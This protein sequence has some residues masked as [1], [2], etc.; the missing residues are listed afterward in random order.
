M[1]KFSI[2]NIIN[3]IIKNI[4]IIF[5]ISIIIFALPSIFYIL[6]NKTLLNF[7]G[8]LEFCFLL[9]N[10]INRLYQALVYTLI[11]SII[12]LCYFIIIKY[13]NQIFKNNKQIFTLI[14]IVSAIFI[15]V[16]PFWCSDLFYYLGIGRITS[17]YNQNP[18]Y[19]DIKSYVDNNNINIEKDTV[20]QKGYTNYWSNT[21]VVY[22]AVWTLICSIVSMLS[23]GNL[24][25]GVLI[26]KILNLCIHL[27]NCYL[28]YKISNKKIFTIIYGFNPFILI[29]GLAN[30]HNDMFVIFFIL[31]ALYVLLKKRRIVPSIFF[32][33]MSADIKYFAIL[34]LPF[35][36]IS[37]FKDKDTKTRIIKCIEY[38]ILFGIF[39]MIPYLLYYRDLNV[40][41]GII[42]QNNKTAKGIY[43]VLNIYFNNIQNLVN[44]VLLSLFAIGYIMICI[45]YL[46]CRD[47]KFTKLMR[48]MYL[49]LLYFIF[50]LITNFQPWYL[51]WLTPLIIWQ[52]HQNI[53]LI[54]QM[55]LLTLYSN[56]VFLMYS[57][58]YIYGVPFFMI[59][60]VGILLCII[61]NK[62][63]ELH[64]KSFQERKL[65]NE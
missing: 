8:N 14:C 26:F 7:N 11:I 15:F 20:M 25:I 37:Y 29:E 50:L 32:L 28:I 46:F 41:M 35:I 34:F 45:K 42:E 47:I 57:E 21:T 10:N 51:I 59:N 62:N 39:C 30:V 16:I 56:I 12:I 6:K 63:R 1:K 61:N 65:Y 5:I 43:I 49:I 40:F 27:G 9:T 38:G 52:N 53:R 48:K 23:F 2:N 13:R 4:K 54:V 22:G 44:L 58:N 24:E 18:Y 36:L 33:A 31:C 17:K 60:T 3:Y 55:Q 19:T 64:K